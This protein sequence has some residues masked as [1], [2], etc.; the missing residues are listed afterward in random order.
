VRPSR[1]AYLL[2]ALWVVLLALSP[3]IA[4]NYIVKIATFLA[5]Y[6]A[7]A[8]SWNFIG[9]YAGYPSFATAAFVGLGSYSGA[10]LQNAGVPMVVAWFIA[11][12]VVVI[13]AAGVGRIILK[14]KGHY[15]AIGSIALVDVLSH[16]ASSWARLTGGGEGLNVKILAGGPDF[17]GMVFLYTMLAIMLAAFATTVIVD[18]NRLGFGL[19]C[20]QQNEDAAD[21]LGVNVMRYKIFAFVLSSVFCGLIGAAYASWVAYI[22]PIDAFSILLTLK[23]AVMVLLGG[24]GTVFGPIVGSAALVIFEEAIWSQFLDLHQGILGLVIV[25][26]IF[27]LPNGLLKIKWRSASRNSGDSR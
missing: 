21:M 17:A 8:M 10:I 25:L 5:M 6:A 23:A 1:F 15:F 14:M 7:I 9:G 27:F 11:A 20:I 16:T 18:R 13:F 19:R 26:L 4:N 3:F 12:G 22:S 24:P 2:F